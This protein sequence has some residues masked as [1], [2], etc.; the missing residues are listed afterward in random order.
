MKAHHL[1]D[2]HDDFG[3]LHRDLLAT[4]AAS[5]GAGSCASRASA[6]A[7]AL[8]LLGC[9]SSPTS[10][11]DT[12]RTSTGTTPARRAGSRRREQKRDVADRAAEAS[13]DDVDGTAGYE[14]SVTN[15]SRVSLASDT[16]FSDGSS[17]ELATVT[18]SVGRGL[19]AAL[20][21]AV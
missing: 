11:T 1:H 17:L 20:T 15:L 2:D 8:Q 14:A 12:G 21:V 4:G 5:I 6:S 18:G 7:G 19:T 9:G 10:P 3:G 13:C 16:V